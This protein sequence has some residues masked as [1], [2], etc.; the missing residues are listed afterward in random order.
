MLGKVFHNGHRVH[1]NSWGGGGSMPCQQFQK[2]FSALQIFW[3]FG[4][5]FGAHCEK[6]IHFGWIRSVLWKPAYSERALKSFGVCGEPFET[7]NTPYGS[8]LLSG[9][10]NS[11]LFF[12]LRANIFFAWTCRWNIY[13]PVVPRVHISGTLSCTGT[14]IA[15][16]KVFNKCKYNTS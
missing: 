16:E 11:K 1:I 5:Q 9:Y 12:C 10:H 6:P 13:L 2:I 7:D 14:Y 3:K 15:V 8:L 4:A